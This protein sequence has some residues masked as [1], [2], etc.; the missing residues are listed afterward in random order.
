MFS[1]L[2]QCNP[3]SLQS[4]DADRAFPPKALTL[5]LAMLPSFLT[6]P[7]SSIWVTPLY[8]HG[9]TPT[10]FSFVYMLPSHK[11]NDSLIVHKQLE[12]NTLLS[13]F[14][15]P[16]MLQKCDNRQGTGI[17]RKDL[18]AHPIQSYGCSC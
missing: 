2:C 16:R 3:A 5:L 13:T 4:T 11:S 14:I 18:S 9:Q 6:F 10:L 7:I 12:K 1:D 15:F 8:C 17:E